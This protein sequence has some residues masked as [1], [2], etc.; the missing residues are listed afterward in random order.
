MQDANQDYFKSDPEITEAVDAVMKIVGNRGSVLPWEQIEQAA[1]CERY[2]GSWSS[3]VKKVRK[4]LMT[5]RMQAT[6]P[7]TNVGLRLLTH[8]ET[9][10]EIPA[11]RQKKMFGQSSRQLQEMDTVDA[12]KLSMG[13]RRLLASQRDRLIAERRAL[14]SARKEILS[15]F[16]TLPI[17]KV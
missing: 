6:W 7:E 13:E 15:S 17:R 4:R 8:K 9:A 10:I 3:I 14:R 11:R 2:T 12:T 1:K 16:E 5:E